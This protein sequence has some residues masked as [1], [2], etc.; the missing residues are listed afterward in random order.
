MNYTQNHNVKVIS[1]IF[2]VTWAISGLHHGFFEMLQGWNPTVNLIISSIGPD[3]QQWIH[4]TDEAFT[5]VPNYRMTG[6][7]SISLSL[8]IIYWS[9]F[10]L[11]RENSG[12]VFLILFIMLCL[13]GG[14]IGFIPYFL[15]TY[16]FIRF[17]RNPTPAWMHVLPVGLTRF[18][19]RIWKWLLTITVTLFLLALEISVFG[20]IP[21][22]DDPDDVL[23]ICWILLGV[24]LILL[25][26]TYL[27]AMV[28]TLSTNKRPHE[29]Y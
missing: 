8:T 17:I 24:S 6:M 25:P 26:L 7:L 14:G 19:K 22:V 9:I 18:S 4:G 13:V 12:R 21:G 11:N 23:L 16:Y 3:Q 27:S 2:G 28:S 5:L 10:R 20:W 15:L 1:M 29:P